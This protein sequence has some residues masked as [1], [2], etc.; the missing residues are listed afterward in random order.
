MENKKEYS[1]TELK[2][3]FRGRTRGDLLKIIQ[4]QS[5][6]LLLQKKKIEVLQSEKGENNESNS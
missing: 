4:E 2:K 1:V 5:K 6:V 3:I